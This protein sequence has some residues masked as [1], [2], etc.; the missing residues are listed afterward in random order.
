MRAIVLGYCI[1]LLIVVGV[2]ALRIE[3]AVQQAEDQTFCIAEKI[4]NAF[5]AEALE[6]CR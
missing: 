3:Q 6:E 5:N 1:V 4:F 2:F